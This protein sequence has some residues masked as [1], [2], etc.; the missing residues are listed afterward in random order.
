MADSPKVNKIPPKKLQPSNLLPRSDGSSADVVDGA[1]FVG[2]VGAAVVLVLLDV[3]VEVLVVASD[4]V[5]VEVVE[6]VVAGVVFG[7]VS[8][9]VVVE[10]VVVVVVVELPSG[11]KEVL[12]L[13]L[14]VVAGSSGS[15]S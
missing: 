8:E 11:A 10:V 6:D 2:V 4:V 13:G 1:G 15:T 5:V 12:N 7:V 3:V 14:M 9:L